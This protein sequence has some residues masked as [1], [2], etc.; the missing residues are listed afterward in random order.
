ME[1]DSRQVNNDVRMPLFRII[2]MLIIL[3]ILF[4]LICSSLENRRYSKGT[5]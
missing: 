5:K 3:F 4:L 1:R 2:I